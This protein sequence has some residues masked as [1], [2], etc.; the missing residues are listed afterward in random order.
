MTSSSPSSSSTSPS[1]AAPL[2]ATVGMFIIDTFRYER[3]DGGVHVVDEGVA[4]VPPQIGGGGTYFAVGARVWLQPHAV[5]M[6][7]DCGDDLPAPMRAKMESFAVARDGTRP[8]E[9]SIFSSSV[10]P[11]VA[12]TFPHALWKWRK[13]P[14][15]TT[16]AVNIYRG[17]YRGFAYLTPKLRLDPVD[18]LDS[19]DAQR[20]LPA[21]IHAIC[22]PPRIHAMLSQIS[23]IAREAG[24]TAAHPPPPPPT[25]RVVWEPIPDS[26]APEALHEA[27]L[28]LC[29][30]GGAPLHA[31]VVS[32]NHV[33]AARFLHGWDEAEV[34]RRMAA[35][36][37]DAAGDAA[38]QAARGRALG[39]ARGWVMDA[40]VTE[41][42]ARWRL[43]AEGV[44]GDAG[45]AGTVVVVRAGGLGSGLAFVEGLNA[46]A[47]L[48]W[49]DAYHDAGMQDRVVDVTGAGNAYLG[50]FT[51]ALA[52]SVGRSGPFTLDRLVKAMECGS[53]SASFTV[54]QRGLPN[55]R[56]LGGR[57]LWNEEEGNVRLDRLRSRRRWVSNQDEGDS[58]EPEL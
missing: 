58:R 34:E 6:I 53:V 30:G 10:A 16:T 27:L 9:S 19:D 41:W 24:E 22:S 49:V 36:A 23:A 44:G 40:L 37:V 11:A 39:G 57:E 7:V 38:G 46:E 4:P 48:A 45:S 29:G 15:R 20:Q 31:A 47:K 33:E 26:A 14:D 32:P 50:G 51:A 3:D 2:V 35:A 13:R 42:V 17:E 54:E 8:A 12:S 25:P 21:Y 18:L 52:A 55:L 56:V 5:K 28:A 43:V 1:S